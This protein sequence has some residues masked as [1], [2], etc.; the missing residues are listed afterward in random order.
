M[1]AVTTVFVAAVLAGFIYRTV[2]LANLF[3]EAVTPLFFIATPFTFLAGLRYFAWEVLFAAVLAAAVW[4]GARLGRRFEDTRFGPVVGWGLVAVL[5][6]V[7]GTVNF[8]HWDL[9]WAA[10]VGFSYDVIG[11]A[12]S[13]GSA[14]D[15]LS[16]SSVSGLVLWWVPLGCLLAVRWMAPQV[17]VRAAVGLSA[18]SLLLLLPS[19]L[20]YAMDLDPDTPRWALKAVPTHYVVDDVA[21]KALRPAGTYETM[22]RGLPELTATGLRIDA[23]RRKPAGALPKPDPGETRWN[24][25][26]VIM[27]SVG[28]RYPF[29]TAHAGV[30]P[31][32][33]LKRLADEGL[34][35]REHRASSNTSPRSIFS[36]MSGIYAL[37]KVN[38]FCTRPDVA[39]PGLGHWLPGYDMFLVT[40]SRLQS[41][42]PRPFL[43]HSGIREMYGYDG[44]PESGR[45]SWPS[46]RHELDAVDLFVER[47]AK[48]P[49]PFFATY[50][51]YAPHYHYYDYGPDYRISKG[52]EPLDRYYDNLR[53]LDTQLARIYQQIEAAGQQERTVFVLVGDHG[54]AFGQ[55]PGNWTHSRQSWEEN[56]RAPAI[57]HQ[58]KLFPPTVVDEV[59]S[60]VD[61]LPTLLDALGIDH[62]P[63]AFQGDS[64]YRGLGSEY[65][66]HYG[67]E[68]TLSSISRARV[69]LQILWR[70]DVC[71]AF[72]LA[73]DPGETTALDCADHPEQLHATL[74]FG[75]FQA[76]ALPAHNVTVSPKTR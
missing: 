76:R 26:Y 3:N 39:I 18:A 51:S 66:F 14:R 71:R 20:L 67:N 63:R 68:D 69:K 58:P 45:P 22:Q 57:F 64:L 62:E 72:D 35:L 17:R 2:W 43:E 47:L 12:W 31:M 55:H 6:W 49:E 34:H 23:W 16:Y 25:V 11:E 50:Y 33:F 27:E 5:F 29:D 32:P 13:G 52:T 54:E 30:V 1:N 53:L 24:V 42:F 75:R 19:P 41:Y 60:H 59:T 36:L 8:I 74:Q 21:T 56:V 10:H 38:M 4:V 65:V 9:L 40:P 15:M 44:I 7:V 73:A 61:L 37:P 48:A 28:A 46:G 70:T